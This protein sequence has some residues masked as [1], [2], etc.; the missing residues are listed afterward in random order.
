MASLTIRN[1]DDE[2]KLRLRIRAAQKGRSME[3]EARQI[4]H[5]ALPASNG[6]VDGGLASAI[7]AIFDPLGGVN[8]DVPKRGSGRE[9]P[10]F[11]G[12]AYDAYDK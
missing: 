11:S 8:L 1:L 3:E 2:L 5:H 12:P 9:P 6:G 10:D 7:A 4:L